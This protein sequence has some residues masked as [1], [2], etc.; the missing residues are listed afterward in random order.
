MKEVGAEVK[1]LMAIKP[2]VASGE[3]TDINGIT[4]DRLGC[5]SGVFGVEV[6]DATGTPTRF[7]VTFRVQNKSGSE[8]WANVSGMSYTF[9]GET[10]ASENAHHDIDVDFRTLGRYVRLVANPTFTAGSSPAVQI[11]AVCIIG[12]AAVTPI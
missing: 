7:G 10:V 2:Q 1:G 8:S 9:S 3:V 11:A 6:G 12:Q 4:I 5:E